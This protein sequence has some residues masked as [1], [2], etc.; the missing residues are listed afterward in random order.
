MTYKHHATNGFGVSSSTKQCKRALIFCR[1]K[2]PL[3]LCL[4][5]MKSA[6]G[7]QNPQLTAQVQQWYFIPLEVLLKNWYQTNFGSEIAPLQHHEKWVLIRAR[8]ILRYCQRGPWVYS[9]DLYS[10]IFIL[11]FSRFCEKKMVIKNLILLQGGTKV[12]TCAMK[13][14]R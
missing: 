9:L 12:L 6:F 14:I 11:C 13:F 2:L 7:T 3:M 4:L 10:Q 5:W 1:C 8:R